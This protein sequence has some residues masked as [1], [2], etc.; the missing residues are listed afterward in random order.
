MLLSIAQIQ[1]ELQERFTPL[2]EEMP[3]L[4]VY[5]LQE[6]STPCSVTQL[7]QALNVT[8]PP[9]FLA[10]LNQYDLDAFTLGPVTFGIES[11]Y[12]THLLDLNGESAESPW[13]SG[14]QRPV[15]Q[16]VIATSDPYAIV[17]DCND[18]KVYA[19]TDTPGAEDREPVAADFEL[20]IRGIGTGFVLEADADDIARQVQSRHPDFW[21][22]I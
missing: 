15:Q 2:L 14:P 19:I 20:F 9:A 6:R 22:Q 7:E 16:L 4:E 13:W 1:Q 12:V 10:F 17:L 21:Q 8:L 3:E 11:D 18:Q 5:L